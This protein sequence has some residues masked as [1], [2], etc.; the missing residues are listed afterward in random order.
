[1]CCGSYPNAAC[2]PCSCKDRPSY[3]GQ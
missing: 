2:H 3:C 1:G